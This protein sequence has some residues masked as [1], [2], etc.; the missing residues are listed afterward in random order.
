VKI[1]E[2]KD[3]RVDE[4]VVAGGAVG[5]VVGL[6]G[7]AILLPVAVGALVGGAISKVHDTN[8]VNKE[9]SGLAD[10]LPAG[11]SA[12]VAVVED[13]YVEVVQKELKNA[14]GKKVHGGEIPNS[15]SSVLKH[16]KDV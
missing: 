15:M 3:W 6:I 13:D 14:G 16:Q 2:Y 12:L 5:A 7:G 8:V 9:W 4:G 1:Q 10:S 11:T